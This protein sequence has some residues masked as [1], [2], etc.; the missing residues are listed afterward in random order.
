MPQYLIGEQILLY[1]PII[2]LWVPAW[3]LSKSYNQYDLFQCKNGFSLNNEQEYLVLM[4]YIQGIKL[5]KII[6][7]KSDLIKKK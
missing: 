5:W 6:H 1:R 7:Q 3:V 2:Q 4:Y